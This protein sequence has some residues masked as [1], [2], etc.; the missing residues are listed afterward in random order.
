MESTVTWR[1]DVIDYNTQELVRGTDRYPLQEGPRGFAIFTV[2]GIVS[3]TLVANA[4]LRAAKE[5]KD[6]V[7]KEARQTHPMKRARTKKPAAVL[8]KPA[9]AQPV[10]SDA[11]EREET[12]EENEGAA[13]AE[14]EGTA[15]AE[16]V[17]AAEDE[18]TGTWSVTDRDEGVQDPVTAEREPALLEVAPATVRKAWCTMWYKRDQA[19]AIRQMHEPKRQLCQW[20]SKEHSEEQLREMAREMV[21][22]LRSGLVAEGRVHEEGLKYLRR[23]AGLE[24]T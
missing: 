4:V 18:G 5:G 2:D 23:T 13:D 20:I 19:A 9:A 8:R 24:S 15:D 22:Q 17:A 11:E 10:D 21:N 14:G 16:G 7:Q 6:K 1:N 3:E 12:E